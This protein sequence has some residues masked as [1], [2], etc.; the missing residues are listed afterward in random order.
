MSDCLENTD[1]CN[2]TMSKRIDN[3]ELIGTSIIK[4]FADN[5]ENAPGQEG[6]VSRGLNDSIVIGLPGFNR[7]NDGVF[8]KK[9]NYV[10]YPK[11]AKDFSLVTCSKAESNKNK[12]IVS[13]VRCDVPVIH[14]FTASK[15]IVMRGQFVVLEWSTT[16]VVSCT[17]LTSLGREISKRP[18]SGRIA[19]ILN[20]SMTVSLVAYSKNGVKTSQDININVN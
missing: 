16:N 12:S 9:D 1:N 4:S 18:P 17:L 2:L 19:I 6:A 8:M 10:R 11:E 7:M 14:S 3:S 13:P 5:V 20:Q 15:T